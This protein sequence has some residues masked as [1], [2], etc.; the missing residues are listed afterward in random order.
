MLGDPAQEGE[1]ASAPPGVRR[2]PRASPWEGR[3]AS[4]A[5]G[6][7]ARAAGGGGA[8]PQAHCGPGP[9]APSSFCLRTGENPHWC[10]TRS[11][12]IEF[13]ILGRGRAGRALAAAWGDRVALTSHEGS[14][15]GWVLL[16]VPDAAVEDLASKFQGRCVH[17][18]GSLHLEGVPCAHP[19]TSFDGEARDWRGTPLAVTG[20]LPLGIRTAFEALGFMPFVLPAHL[21]P[22]YHA[23]AVLSS[24]HAASL[25]V[26]AARL[27]EEA[28]VALPGRGVSAPGGSDPPQCGREGRRGTHRPL[29]EEGRGHHR[30]GRGGSAC[31]MAGDFPAPGENDLNPLDWDLGNIPPGIA[32]GGRRWGVPLRDPGPKG[33]GVGGRPGGPS[34]RG[35]P[36][37]SSRRPCLEG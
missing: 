16:A 12:A 36:S 18:S 30:A 22:L 37:A 27:L 4:A 15:G 35:P 28:G 33:L 5:S 24:G 10:H 13:T 21:K 20:E 11:M 25:W 3:D 29:R 31:R 14:P 32:W 8:I 19:L 2:R 9:W 7:E 6:T 23:C 1:G 17:L 26:G 34:V